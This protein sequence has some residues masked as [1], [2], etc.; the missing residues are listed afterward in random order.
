MVNRDARGR[1]IAATA[2]ALA[3]FWRWYRGSCLLDEAGRPLLAVHMTNHD[4]DSFDHDERQA[5]YVREQGMTTW[6]GHDL[7]FPRTGFFFFTGEQLPPRRE[8]I[9]VPVYLR[10]TNPLD[11]R[12]GLSPAQAAEV[13]DFLRSKVHRLPTPGYAGSRLRGDVIGGLRRAR[14]EGLTGEQLWSLVNVNCYAQ[15]G[16][17][18][19][20]L[21]GVLGMDGVIFPANSAGTYLGEGLRGPGDGKQYLTVVAREP[22][23]IKSA[24]GNSGAFDGQNPSL[25]DTPAHTWSDDQDDQHDDDAPRC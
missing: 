19:D 22:Q 7:V 6:Y 13:I 14:R 23:Q 17:V 12:R 25:C 10:I 8:A 2:Q 1:R 11:F 20:D 5:A 4:F 3:S 21:L 15:R 16:R 18:Y 24:V 9:A